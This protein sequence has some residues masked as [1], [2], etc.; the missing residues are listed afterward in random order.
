[1]V[2]N[3]WKLNK[4]AIS[5][6]FPLPKQENILQ[7]LSGSQWLSTLDPISGLRQR[8]PYQQGPMVDA[9]QH[10]S[11]DLTE[12]PIWDMYSELGERFKEK[13]LSVVLAFVASEILEEPDY[14]FISLNS[15][16]ICLPSAHEFTLEQISSKFLKY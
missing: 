3:Y 13:L 9:T 10:I 5:D 1:M 2:I 8:I 7:A 14:S 16:E 6:E 12:D 4:V 11:L 15:L